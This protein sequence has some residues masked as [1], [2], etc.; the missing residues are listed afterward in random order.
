MNQNINKHL[1]LLNI[2]YWNIQGLN[3]KINGSNLNKLNDKEF[4]DTVANLDIFCLSETHIGSD[5]LTQLKNFKSFK[6][7]RNSSGNNKFSGGL[8]LFT[9]KIVSKSIKVFKNSDPDVL[10]V[11]LN[12]FFFQF[13]M[14]RTFISAST[15]LALKTLLIIRN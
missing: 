2:G 10:W 1:R 3:Q 9:S 15:I 7:C 6:S 11:K 13:C 14:K 5:F 12:R 8:S 4:L